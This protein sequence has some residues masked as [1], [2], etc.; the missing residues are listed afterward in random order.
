MGISSFLELLSQKLETGVQLEL[1]RA[2]VE[3]EGHAVGDAQADVGLA[4]VGEIFPDVRPM[5]D[6]VVLAGLDE[7]RTRQDQRDDVS[8]G[9][10]GEP[11]GQ[12]RVLL[13]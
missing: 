13:G 3:V 9:E 8:V 5:G 4:G 6:R 2:V 7:Q 12:E 11:A 10:L 1:V